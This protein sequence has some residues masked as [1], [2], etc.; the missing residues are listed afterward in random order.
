MQ[1]EHNKRLNQLKI[2]HASIDILKE[3]NTQL[4]EKM[5]ILKEKQHQANQSWAWQDIKSWA[6]IKNS[7]QW[8]SF[9]LFENNHHKF[10]KFLN[11]FIFTDED[12]LT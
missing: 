12:E 2:N 4:W 6:V 1:I 7:T 11:S 5:L 10:F 3:I 9:T 8:E